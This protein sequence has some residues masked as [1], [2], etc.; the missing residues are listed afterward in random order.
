MTGQ[1]LPI[2][3]IAPS[4]PVAA[5]RAAARINVEGMIAIILL[6][7]AWQ[8]ASTS[9]P[10]YLFPSLQ[11]IGG[12]LWG[13][14]SD[15]AAFGVV[16]VTYARIVAWLAAAF[17]LSTALGIWAARRA[18]VDRATVPL[19]QLK[20]GIPGICWAIFAIIWF[21]DMETRIAFVVVTS[22]LPSLFFQARDGFRA[23]PHDLWDMVRALRPSSTAMFTKLVLPGMLPAFLT[24]LRINLGTAARVTITAELLAGISGIGHQ[25]RTA[26]EQFR[27]DEV[28]AWTIPIALF[29]LLTDYGM[30]KLERGLLRWRRQPEAG[31]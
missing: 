22:T 5:P 1:I 29:V 19:I 8:I 21:E 23:I 11:V 31:Q 4:A 17:I 15:P 2:S 12:A 24:G 18:S 14:F 26:Q 30:G 13:T 3:G 16:L 9:F 6:L 27:M 20:Q 10:P 7:V 25:L 28:L